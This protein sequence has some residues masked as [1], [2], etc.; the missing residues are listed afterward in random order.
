MNRNETNQLVK[1][2]LLLTMVGVISKLLSAG[3]RIPLQNVTGDMGIY[4]YQQ[5]Y[6]VLGIGLMLALYGFPS[7]IAKLAAEEQS[8]AQKLS[9]TSFYFPIFLIL[10]MLNGSLALFIYMNAPYITGWIGDERLTEIY[11]LGALTFL[12]IPVTALLRGTFQGNFVMKPTAFSQLAEQ[13]FRVTI[14][15]TSAIVIAESGK[16]IYTI[17]RA[18]VFASIIGLIVATIVLAGFFW[19]DKPFHIEKRPYSMRHYVHT[20]ITIGIVATLNHMVLLLLQFADTFTL[21][22]SLLNGGYSQLMAMEAKGVFDRGQPLIQIGT[23]LGSSF[24]LALM[25]SVS[26]RKLTEQPQIFYPYI[27]GAMLFS[28]YLATGATVGLIA[29]FPEVNQALFQDQQGNAA[30]RLLMVAVLLSSL[31]ITAAA[32]LQ[33]LG[34]IKRIAL[35][36]LLACFMKWIGNQWFVPSMGIFGSSFATVLALL[37]FSVIALTELRRK[38]PLLQLLRNVQWKALLL[39]TFVMVSYLWIVKWVVHPWLPPTRVASFLFVGFLSI[40]GATVYGYCLIRLKAFTEQQLQM[41]PS[42]L[43][44]RFIRKQRYR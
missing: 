10:C 6:P 40:T 1:G 21:F 25:P 12:F 3:Y 36:I 5:I 7:A 11:Y 15:I 35:L 32:I 17:G 19:R 18:A 29:I 31:A 34:Y 22:P 30:L 4:V 41:L 2:A 9:L 44:L 33:G 16:P 13:L 39:A 14:I 20:I 8:H 27:R 37:V 43:S 38:L 23:V 42:R 28:I 26:K 24:A